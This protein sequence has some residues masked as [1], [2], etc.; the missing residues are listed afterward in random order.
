MRQAI[1]TKYLGATNYRGSRVKA[2][3]Y[4][5]SVT[6][7]WD[8]ALDSEANHANAAAAL[9]KKYGW[10]GTWVGGGRPDNRGNV[11][12]CVAN[13]RFF[14]DSRRESYEAA[15]QIVENVAVSTTI[16]AIE[17]ADGNDY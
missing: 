6:I 17:T 11:Y 16:T 9:C 10:G 12:V 8:D 14:T 15:L 13:G 2:T 3:A 4:A 7:S 1:I 5:G